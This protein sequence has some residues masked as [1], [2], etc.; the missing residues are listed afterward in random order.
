MIINHC[1]RSDRNYS[2][3]VCA[4]VHGWIIQCCCFAA[5]AED[6]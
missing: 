4:I 6:Y 5:A 2:M 1:Y 3:D